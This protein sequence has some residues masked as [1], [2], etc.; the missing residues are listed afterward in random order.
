MIKLFTAIRKN[1]FDNTVELSKLS[2]T[3]FVWAIGL[4]LVYVSNIYLTRLIGLT[5]YG[6]YTVFVSWISLIST[7]LAFGWDGY[8][9]QKIPQLPKNK[10]GKITSAYI[11]K[12]A[13]ATFL[14][15]YAVFTL[16]ILW[17]A[18]YNKSALDFLEADQ[19]P[20]FL[21]LI[22]LF[23]G[24]ALL[25][26]FLKI[27][28]WVTRVQWLEDLLKPLV[29][30]I[31]ILWYYKYKIQLSLS[32]LYDI[33][34]L[35]FA[36][37][38]FCLL[39]FAIKVY[40]KNFHIEPAA[41]VVTEKWVN[42]CFYF[43]CI[44]LGYNIFT[45]MELLFLGF[46][47]KNEDAARYQIL[48]RISDLVFVPDVLFNYFL[49]QKFA[50][51]FGER[52]IEA[53]KNLFKNSAKT[54]L[55]L[56]ILCFLGVSAIGYFYLQSFGVASPEMYILLLILCSA[57][58][59]NSLFGSSNLVLKASGNERYSFYALLIIL[60]AEAI[61]NAILIPLY[62]LKAAIAVSWASIFLYNL[63]LSFFVHKRLQFYSKYSS[64]LFSGSDSNK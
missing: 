9:I 24:L 44:F 31:V 46:F 62:G 45:R 37:V 27:F 48:L 30:F 3:F 5:Q 26:S 13:I 11:L 56:A 55:L 29:L 53:A 35:V 52:N 47:T 63:L 41:A 19:V 1:Y 14:G 54:I 60:V 33:N 38:T 23:T 15:L 32:A 34:L 61:A 51:H 57:P 59:F 2:K 22:F 50:H 40:R 43:M 8:L 6:K 18:N 64:I 12:K 39:F 36:G 25:R 17:L 49:P 16:L 42:K 7:L 20:A 21:S 4:I 58:I 28:H 10:S